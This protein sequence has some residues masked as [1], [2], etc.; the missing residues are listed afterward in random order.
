MSSVTIHFSDDGN[1][2]SLTINEA[3]QRWQSAAV[4]KRPASQPKESPETKK[5]KAKKNAS[6]DKG[7]GKKD[8]D[9][10]DGG[11]KDAGKKDADK[12]NPRR[13]RNIRQKRMPPVNDWPAKIQKVRNH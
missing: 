10:K 8:G 2:Q 1:M 7:G 6:S 5:Q 4:M 12:K 13:R 9:K 11:K 3:F